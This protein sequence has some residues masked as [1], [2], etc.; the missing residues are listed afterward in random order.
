MTGKI[1]QGFATHANALAAL[2]IDQREKLNDGVSFL[3][4]ADEAFFIG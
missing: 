2:R 4:K 1:P 3:M